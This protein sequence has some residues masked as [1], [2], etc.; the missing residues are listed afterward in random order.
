MRREIYIE[1]GGRTYGPYASAADALRDGFR[2]PPEAVS[3]QPS[4][5]SPEP[6]GGRP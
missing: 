3:D 2:L 6:Q 1:W 4:A 5:I